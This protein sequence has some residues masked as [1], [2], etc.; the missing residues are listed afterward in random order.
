[1]IA[2]RGD[3][4]RARRH[5]VARGRRRARD[6]QA[7][8]RRLRRADARRRRS[9]RSASTRSH[10]GDVITIDG[11]TGRVFVGE[12]PLVPPQINEDF[13]TILG[14][15]DAQR[16]LKVRA[17]ADNPE[18]AAR[19]RE[20]GAR[21]NRPLPDR[22]HVLRRPAARRA[23]DD[24]RRHRVGPPRRAR[25]AAA[26]PAERL[27]GDL[28]GDGGA[29]GDD[30]AARPAAARVPARR[31]RGDRRARCARASGRCTSRTRCS[32]RAAA[33]SA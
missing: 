27:R 24:P 19:A 22:A 21:G 10:E 17:N 14:W 28:R 25:P 6:G 4:H 12:V 33:G 13:E 8:R 29:A 2:A 9:R 11:G 20:F 5:D 1:M 7:V 18:D 16:R 30:P 31:A 3:P 15:A 26:V 32:A 23:G